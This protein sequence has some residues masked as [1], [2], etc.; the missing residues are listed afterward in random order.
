M[1]PRSRLSPIHIKHAIETGSSKLHGNLQGV[2]NPML[3]MDRSIHAGRSQ[4]K[5]EDKAVRLETTDAQ[6]R[7]LAT[8]IPRP[9]LLDWDRPITEVLPL[10]TVLEAA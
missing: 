7:S 6:D 4:T 10:G 2:G 3:T 1:I 5:A 8:S 9:R